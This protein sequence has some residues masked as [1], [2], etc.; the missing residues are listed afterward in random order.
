MSV[1]L[2]RLYDIHKC[3]V[4]NVYVYV[5]TAG[6]TFIPRQGSLSTFHIHKQLREPIFVTG[7]SVCWPLIYYEYWRKHYGYLGPLYFSNMLW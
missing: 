5:D 7:E 1:R 4:V 3:K 6:G 2:S